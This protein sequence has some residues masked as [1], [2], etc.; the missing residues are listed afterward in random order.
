MNLFQ[1]NGRQMDI[2]LTVRE[3]GDRE[4]RLPLGA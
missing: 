2:S 4:P 1:V 3:A